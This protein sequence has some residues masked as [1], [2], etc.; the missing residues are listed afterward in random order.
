MGT[1]ILK[2]GTGS[3]GKQLQVCQDTWAH[4]VLRG[5][6]ERKSHDFLRSNTQINPGLHADSSTAREKLAAQ[7]V[8]HQILCVTAF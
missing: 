8:G 6:A 1:W 2:V 3:F 5:V 7:K 4:R